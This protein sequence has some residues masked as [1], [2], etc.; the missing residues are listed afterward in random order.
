[1]TDI[2]V[3]S[4]DFEFLHYES[5]RFILIKPKELF[6]NTNGN[7]S[8]IHHGYKTC[9]YAAAENKLDKSNNVLR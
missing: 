6:T 8:Q 9:I 5:T 1:M 7:M 4:L 3:K 2:Y